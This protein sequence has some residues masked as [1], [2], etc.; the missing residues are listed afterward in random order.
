MW[1]I[2]GLG[3]HHVADIAE[4]DLAAFI[5]GESA[6]LLQV[7]FFIEADHSGNDYYHSIRLQ[8]QDS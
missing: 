1:D 6:Y 4:E 5:G 3:V 8:I 7:G 2:G